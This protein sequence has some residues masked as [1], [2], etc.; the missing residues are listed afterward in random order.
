MKTIIAGSRT[1]TDSLEVEAAIK[2]SGFTITE[3]LCGGAVGADAL[4]KI[5]AVKNNIP[6]K[7]FLPDWTTYGKSA[8]PLRNTQMATYVG[9]TG[10]LIALWDGVSKGTQDMIQKAEKFN[11]KMYIHLVKKEEKK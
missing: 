4:G 6:V 1:I 8:G 5:W 11:L 10:A 7:L 9:E 3:V 2:D